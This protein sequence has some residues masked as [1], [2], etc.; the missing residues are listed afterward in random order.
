MSEIPR[1]SRL[2][3]AGRDL[4]MCFRCSGRATD[5]HHRRRRRESHGSDAHSPANIISLCRVC[6]AWVHANPRAAREQGYIVVS[7]E[8]DPG[9]VPV[10]HVIYRWVRLHDD[11]TFRLLQ[12]CKNCDIPRVVG[13]SGWCAECLILEGEP[14]ASD[15]AALR[16]EAD[17]DR[18]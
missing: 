2:L 18:A 13:R 4:G 17:R 1:R 3:V 11:G 7:S 9:S 14:G 15:L 10:W 6:H 8:P 5:S 12:P 16:A